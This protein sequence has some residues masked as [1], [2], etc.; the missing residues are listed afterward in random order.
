MGKVLI[1]VEYGL[2]G[3]TAQLDTKEVHWDDYDIGKSDDNEFI[4]AS[5]ERALDSLEDAYNQLRSSLL[6]Q[7]PNKHIKTNKSA[8]TET[9]W[10]GFVTHSSDVV[11]G[12]HP[13]IVHYILDGF[14][15]CHGGPKIDQ[16]KWELFTND[17]VGHFKFCQRCIQNGAPHFDEKSSRT[18][19]RGANESTEL[20][21]TSPAG[22]RI[23]P[24]GK[25]I[26]SERVSDYRPLPPF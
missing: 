18:T 26:Q 21:T 2:V 22:D 17:S 11:L 14:R 15:N 5:R 13:K 3:M 10:W 20:P 16:S 4:N 19:N 23:Y 6:S 8:K 25:P 12:I 9:G 1:H 7:Q 24:E